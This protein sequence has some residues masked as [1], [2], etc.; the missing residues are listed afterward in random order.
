MRDVSDP[1]ALVNEYNVVALGAARGIRESIVGYINPVDGVHA[2][3]VP[4]V[5]LSCIGVPQ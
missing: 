4:P 2:A 1:Q 5:A 3:F